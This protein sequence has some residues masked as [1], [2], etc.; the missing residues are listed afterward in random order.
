MTHY[1]NLDLHCHGS[2]THTGLRLLTFTQTEMGSHAS[3]IHNIAR[4]GVMQSLI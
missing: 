4:Y 3:A 2:I 1:I